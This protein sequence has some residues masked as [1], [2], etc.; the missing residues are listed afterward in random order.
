MRQVFGRTVQL[1]AP[2]VVFA[3]PVGDLRGMRTGMCFHRKSIGHA[4]CVCW[5]R[6]AKSAYF[7]PSPAAS[8][9]AHGLLSNNRCSSG[10]QWS[11]ASIACLVS[12][13]WLLLSLF[14]FAKDVMCTCSTWP[15]RVFRCPCCH[16]FTRLVVLAGASA[17]RHSSALRSD[18][19]WLA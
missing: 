7:G 1:P 16:I 18:H 15:S 9:S 6:A 10:C 19:A 2:R 14:C 12:T 3:H 17:T 11:N 5:S 13:S 8:C 4:V